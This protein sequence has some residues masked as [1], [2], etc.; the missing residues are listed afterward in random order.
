MLDLA[1]GDQIL[2]RAGDVLD[3]HIGID[4]V[5]VEQ[6]DHL[7]PQPLQR[8][9][10]HLPDA[11]GAAVEPVSTARAAGTKVVAELGGDD[12]ILPERLQRLA[13]EFLVGER[14]IDLGGVEEGDAALYRRSDQRD[15]L[16][17]VRSRAAVMIQ[18]HAAE[19]DGRD[20][21]VAIAKLARLHFHS[22]GSLGRE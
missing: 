7:D 11:F 19:A 20:C 14:A 3:R 16:L 5:L 10:G 15:H 9:F 13:H 22:P 21:K 18:A 4:P 2:H 6:V 12:D 1:L 8:V 17:A